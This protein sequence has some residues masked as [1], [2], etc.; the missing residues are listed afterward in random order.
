MPAGQRLEAIL[1]AFDHDLRRLE[2]N[3]IARLDSA[4]RLAAKR[5]EAELRISY[6]AALQ[7]ATGSALLR[8]ARARILLE[9]VR[10]ALDLTTGAD[11]NSVF[12]QLV[13]DSFDLGARNAV[14]ALGVYQ[15]SVVGLSSNARLNV[16][17]RA[18]Q[19]SRRL[20]HH[21]EAFA[22]QAEELI[23]D[24][25]VRG[26][27]WSKTASELRHA[28]G[29][30]RHHAESIVRTESVTA[31]DA[32]RREAYREND[33]E[34][35]QRMATADN[36]VCGYCAARAG[37][38]YRLE[39]APA[40]LHPNDRCYNAP[41]RQEWQELGLTDD[42]WFR[43]HRRETIERSGKEPNYG[44]AP[45]ER[46]AGVTPPE[47]VWVPSQTSGN[48]STVSLPS[49]RS[50][51]HVSGTPPGI[52]TRGFEQRI[53]EAADAIDTI[54]G[55]PIPPVTVELVQSIPGVSDAAGEYRPSTST[56]VLVPA[57][58]ALER[59]TFWHEF[60]HHV[61]Y[62]LLG[63]GY[64]AGSPYR[65][66]A[67]RWRHAVY[68]SRTVL[69]LE[70]VRKKALALGPSGAEEVRYFEYLQRRQEIW[71]RA[72]EQWIATRSNQPAI[73]AMMRNEAPEGY[74]PDAEFQPIAGELDAMFRGFGWL[75]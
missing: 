9:Q 23:I 66:E 8:E 68:N 33:V 70:A 37:N 6:L 41:W 16:A 51:I 32:A 63:N 62:H 29:T 12:A 57:S 24:G 13:G 48:A 75:R 20:A 2:R 50:N 25:V 15:A 74:W 19:T 17:A 30:T 67:V 4:L 31:S 73:L 72:Y 7:D 65:R 1:T 59:A 52:G 18:T 71:A 21:G 56:I 27:S 45:F 55:G 64:T 39:D 60:G 10:G 34:Y 47:P 35:V 49:I 46:A 69:D 40:A 5:L 42:E 26:R 3:A 54:H 44:P 14:D 53:L 22:L 11:A 28:V 58:A 36:R 43:E 38:V 61:D